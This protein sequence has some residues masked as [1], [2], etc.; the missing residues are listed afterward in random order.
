[1]T[2]EMKK[3]EQM[4]AYILLW[5]V[6]DKQK[7]AKKIF[8]D[9]VEKVRPKIDTKDEWKNYKT[10]LET[11]ITGMNNIID[12]IDCFLNFL[13]KWYDVDTSDLDIS[14]FK[15]FIDELKKQFDEEFNHI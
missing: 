9:F 11:T 7:I 5:S 3:L 10:D 13:S 1:M 2:D 4:K 15:E 14:S 8:C 12:A 6:L